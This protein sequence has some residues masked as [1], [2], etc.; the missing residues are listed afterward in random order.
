[1]GKGTINSHIGDG[2][3]SVELNFDVSRV[4]GWITE[5]TAAISYW[6]TKIAAMDP[7]LE[8]DLAT[9]KKAALEKRKSYLEGNTPADPTISA[10]CAD[11]TEDL[12]GSVGT[13]EVPGERGTVLIQPGHDGNA[14]YDSDR[15]G[16]IQPIIASPAAQVFYNLAMLPGWQKWKPNFRFG[17]ITA[18]DTDLDTCSVD[19]EA[20]ASSAQGLDVNQAISI[21]DITIEYMDCDSAAFEVGDDVLIKFEG[22]DW[23]SPK[24]VGFKDNPQ[25][26]G[27]SEEW[28]LTLC[29]NHDWTLYDHEIDGYDCK[30][31]PFFESGGWGTQSTTLIDGILRIQTSQSDNSY[32]YLEIEFR[33]NSGVT[34]PK[35]AGTMFL[36]V[37]GSASFSH[38]DSSIGLTIQDM[39]NNYVNF[40]FAANKVLSPP[41]YL[42]GWNG[43][44]EQ[45]IDLALYGLNPS[46]PVK[47]IKFNCYTEKSGETTDLRFDYIKFQ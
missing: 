26:C 40:Y 37:D 12:S 47:S 10:W 39:D 28:G 24:V 34:G 14:A 1:M 32:T 41:N 15:D 20:A 35:S 21:S 31:L 30:A 44:A 27:W 18:I 23:A 11:L 25:P 29:E 43:G 46:V 3:Y 33:D 5:L 38:A 13:I 6:E 7:G 4:D 2:Q 9:L 36:K 19:V 45:E 8:K 17:T 42:I 22:N 16:Q